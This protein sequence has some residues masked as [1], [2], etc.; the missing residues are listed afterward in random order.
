MVEL[1]IRNND[2]FLYWGEVTKLEEGVDFVFHVIEQTEFVDDSLFQQFKSGKT[3]PYC[4]RCTAT[5]LQSAE[6][7]MYI[8]KDQLGMYPYQ[9][10]PT[11][12][13]SVVTVVIK[14]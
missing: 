2:H 4:K 7:L 11:A 10:T 5:K 3:E 9:Y 6:K 1:L 14:C 8:C 13:P 12:T